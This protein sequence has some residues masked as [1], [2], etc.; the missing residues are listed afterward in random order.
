MSIVLIIH[1]YNDRKMSKDNFI[2]FLEEISR[3]K[4]LK[5]EVSAISSNEEFINLGQ[6]TG[7]EFS[8][9]DINEIIDELKNKPKFLGLLAESV[10]AIFSPAH[11]RYPATGMQPFYG[12]DNASK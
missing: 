2:E 4:S 10:L 7:F 9:E 6:A 8:A 12:E 5:D 1:F 3:S 11:D